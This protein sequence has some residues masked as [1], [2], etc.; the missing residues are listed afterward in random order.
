VDPK[1]G[2]DIW[3]TSLFPPTRIRTLDI[4]LLPQLSSARKLL[5][6]LLLLVNFSFFLRVS[7]RKMQNTMRCC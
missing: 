2:L 1:G 4:Q 3:E 6:S 5:L 7:R